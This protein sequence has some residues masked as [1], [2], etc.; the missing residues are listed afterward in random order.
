MPTSFALPSIAADATGRNRPARAEP[1]RVDRAIPNRALLAER[2]EYEMLRHARHERALAL[3]AV[4]VER[5]EAVAATAE[6]LRR[7][8]RAQDTVARVGGRA[9]CVLAPET[10]RYAATHLGARLRDALPVTRVGVALFPHDA[11]SA[12]D[13][14]ARA[15]AGARAGGAARRAA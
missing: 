14:V 11:R 13:L 3:F 9:L 15:A 6:A 7:A 12:R 4:E 1:E 8:L 10:D 5:E 2:L